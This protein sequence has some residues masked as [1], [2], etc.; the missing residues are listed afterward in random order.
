MAEQEGTGLLMYCIGAEASALPGSGSGLQ[1]VELRRVVYGGL[2]AVVSPIMDRAR[3]ETPPTVDLL[4]Y[5]RVVH[6]QHAVADVVPMRFGSVLSDEVE[7]RA[8]LE[9]RREAYL[10]TL[11]RIAGCVELGIRALVSLSGP[12][13]TAEEIATPMI[14]SG[15]DY[16]KARQRRYSADHRLRDQ[17][18]A[19]E[20]ALLAKV[21]P[22]CREHRMEFS[23]SRSGAPALCS[24]YFLVPREEVSAFRDA[25]TPVANDTSAKLAVSGPWPPFNFVA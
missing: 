22:L 11:E 20:Q 17:C 25:L 2:A 23:P 19:L 21:A 6:S 4:E 16:L 12:L 9:A 10:H 3:V 7:V 15:A 24:L 14:R 1:G 18:T 5:E 13:E 8:H